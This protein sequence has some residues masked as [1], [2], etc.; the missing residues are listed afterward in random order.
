MLFAVNYRRRPIVDDEGTRRL[1]DIFLAWTP[2]TNVEVFRHYHFARGGAGIVLLEVAS[3]SALYQA[4]TTF[5]PII[6]YEVEPLLDVK[7]AVAIKLDVDAW[8]S[9][10]G[11][12]QNGGHYLPN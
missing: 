1:I 4:L 2:A 12:A 11:A 3:A 10:I 9:E 5:D 8:V 6:E 7:E